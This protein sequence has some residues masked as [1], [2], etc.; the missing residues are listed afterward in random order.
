[1]L[2][3]TLWKDADFSLDGKQIIQNTTKRR[4]KIQVLQRYHYG[5]DLNELKYCD[6]S[7]ITNQFIRP[8]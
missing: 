5:T 4:S 3:F 6:D 7:N 1:M 8:Y 2:L